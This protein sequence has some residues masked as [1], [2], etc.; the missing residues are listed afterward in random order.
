MLKISHKINIFF[1]L[2]CVLK[3]YVNI[4]YLKFDLITYKI[5]KVFIVLRR[6]ME[7]NSGGLFVERD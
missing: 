3:T 6:L 2:I 4:I 1:I 5:E 7:S